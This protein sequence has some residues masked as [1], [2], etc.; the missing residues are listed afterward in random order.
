MSEV[1]ELANLL[2]E[3]VKA[4]Q[5]THQKLVELARKSEDHELKWLVL[6][7][8]GG[9][10]SENNLSRYTNLLKKKSESL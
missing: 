1:K 10:L 9:H 5:E 3:Q 7:E 8:I 6:T 4:C 2:N